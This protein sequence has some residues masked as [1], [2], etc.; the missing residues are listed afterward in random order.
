GVIVGVS[1][2]TIPQGERAVLW[3]ATGV[4]DLNITL[5]AG[6]PG[7]V[8]RGIN[9]KGQ[10]VGDIGGPGGGGF[11]WEAGTVTLL[12]QSLFAQAINSAGTIVG[13]SDGPD[14]DPYFH[15]VIWKN[16]SI[17]DLNNLVPAN[18]GVLLE[19]ASG[20]NDKGQIVGTGYRLPVTGDDRYDEQHAYLLTP[21]GCDPI[22]EAA[23]ADP[24]SIDSLPDRD[25]DGIPD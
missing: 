24:A 19:R 16:G 8:G 11:Q 23:L 17:Q 4:H 10:I 3:D 14:T 20:I 13:Y 18:S 25:G 12:G 22:D 7:S 21:T 5:P 6:S 9:A 1:G 15:A 2:Q